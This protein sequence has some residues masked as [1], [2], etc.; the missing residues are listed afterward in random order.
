MGLDRA[1]KSP[2]LLCYDR[3]R[4]LPPAAGCARPDACRRAASIAL[5][6]PAGT[7]AIVFLF[8]ST[9]CPIS[10]RYAP[11]V[12]RLAEGFAPKGVVFRLVYPNPAETPAAIREHM[13]AF[14]Y[15]GA[16]EAFRDPAHA[17]VKLAGATVTPEAAVSLAAASSIAAA[18]TIATSSSASSVPQPPQHD[19]ADALAA[20]VAGKPV[21]ARRRRRSGVSSRISRDE[22]RRF[23]ADS[24][25]PRN[26]LARFDIVVRS[27]SGPGLLARLQRAS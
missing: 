5:Q 21:A 26:M 9:D 7:K 16:A 25:N 18:S 4:A 19:L 12:R 14:Q 17:L 2:A 1:P 3:L 11:E 13:A 24:L 15:A 10:N 23:N 27:P 20:V 8:T 6:A 22:K